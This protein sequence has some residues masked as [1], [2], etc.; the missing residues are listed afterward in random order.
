[1]VIENLMGSRA[2]V[3]MSIPSRPESEVGVRLR[4]TWIREPPSPFGRMVR[5]LVAGLVVAAVLFLASRYLTRAIGAHH[6][7]A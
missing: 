5:A 3:M 1:L 2:P 4:A 7:V 6:P